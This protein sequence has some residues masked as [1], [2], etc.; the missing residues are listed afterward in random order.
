[1]S[2]KQSPQVLVVP[3]PED[4]DLINSNLFKNSFNTMC[5][6]LKRNQKYSQGILHYDLGE[7]NADVDAERY[8]KVNKL[9]CLL[10][11]K[12]G[13]SAHS[14]FESKRDFFFVPYKKTEIVVE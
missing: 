2:E 6:N 14:T 13:W 9:L 7:G 4:C 11:R 8:D 1:M 12:N 5:I 10:A 3:S